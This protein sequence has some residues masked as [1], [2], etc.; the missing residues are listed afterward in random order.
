MLKRILVTGAGGPG[1]LNLSR[2][3]LQMR[4]QPWLL[5]VD[6]SNH[7]VYLALGH[8][9]ALVPRASDEQAYIN[10]LN[11]L[12]ERHAI[13]F[14]FPNN[15]LEIRVLSARRE[16]LHAPVFLPNVPALDIAN[17]KWLS[18]QAFEKAG[19]PLPRT[20]LLESPAQLRDAFNSLQVSEDSPV[21]VRGA[22]I[23]GKGIGVASLPCRTVE[24]AEQWVEYWRGWGEMAASEYLP[25]DNLTWMG[26]FDRGELMTSQ[27]R[28][29]LA[30]VIPHVSP[31]GITGAPAISETIHD[32]E[33]NRLGFAAVKA[34][35]P[36]YHGVA[37]VDMKGDH[38]GQPRIT[39][40]N[41]GR[42]GTTHF[43]YSA[44]GANFPEYL[45]RLASGE[46]LDLP[47]TNVLPEG[48]VW[49][50]TLD[51]SP[52]LTTRE[53]IEA[54]EYPSFENAD[55]HWPRVPQTM[56]DF[57]SDTDPYWPPRDETT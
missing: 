26:L 39:E 7:Y 20:I 40:V 4:P 49:I 17:S 3:L 8:E 38:A 36:S 54:G 50:R 55:A 33:V 41:A 46:S 24:Q 19:L 44:A 1:A 34:I 27:G 13:D 45:L 22:G 28:R 31:S 32:E 35:D 5:A 56:G 2:S 16:E 12:I 30:Y 37:F 51:A 48:L 53:A 43:F 14:V 52:V 23:P 57:S 47:K 21:W 25:G 18:Y 15:S 9:R 42:F 11:A 10:A 6:A 29:R